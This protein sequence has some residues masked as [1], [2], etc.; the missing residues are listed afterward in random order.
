MKQNKSF[1]QTKNYS[2][3]MIERNN[4]ILC[5]Q[6]IKKKQIFH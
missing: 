1:V 2:K 5:T 3:Q 4:L 6:G